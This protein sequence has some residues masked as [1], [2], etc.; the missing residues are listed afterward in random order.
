MFYAKEIGE[1]SFMRGVVVGLHY[2]LATALWDNM[3]SMQGR[4]TWQ[5]SSLARIT[6]AIRCHSR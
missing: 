2:G 3:Y 5:T 1:I 6:S 4:S